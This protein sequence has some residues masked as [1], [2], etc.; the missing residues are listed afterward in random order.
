VEK[1]Y[2]AS[3]CMPILKCGMATKQMQQYI[4]V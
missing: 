1:E 3:Y 2:T 4:D